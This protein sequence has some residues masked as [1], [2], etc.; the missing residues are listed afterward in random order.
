MSKEILIVVN[1]KI[2]LH[3]KCILQ[4]LNRGLG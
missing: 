3:I 2:D 1:P 4:I